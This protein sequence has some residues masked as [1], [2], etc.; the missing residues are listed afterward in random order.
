MI[1]FPSVG[2]IL[3][4]TNKHNPIRLFCA[5]LCNDAPTFIVTLGF[6]LSCLWMLRKKY[7]AVHGDGTPLLVSIEGN[8]AV[9]HS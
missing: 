4:F 8:D 6:V 7:K 3:F 9:R 2:T 1:L 5:P